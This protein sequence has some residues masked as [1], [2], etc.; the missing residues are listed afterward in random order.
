MDPC[1]RIKDAVR[2]QVKRCVDVPAQ[3]Q[4]IRQAVREGRHKTA[5]RSGATW[6]ILWGLPNWLTP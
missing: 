1:G 5:P 4:E 3:A 2:E 6:A